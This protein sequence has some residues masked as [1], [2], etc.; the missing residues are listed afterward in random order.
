MT[1]TTV[2]T[3]IMVWQVPHLGNVDG[4]HRQP[5]QMVGRAITGP[6]VMELASIG[7][8]PGMMQSDDGDIPAMKWKR[9]GITQVEAVDPYQ[10]RIPPRSQRWSSR[11]CN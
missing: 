2:F 8:P 4:A 6:P 3:Q 7:P 11:T 5:P 9:M 1:P 10:L